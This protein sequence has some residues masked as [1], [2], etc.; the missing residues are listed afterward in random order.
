M[1]Y[2]LIQGYSRYPLYFKT[3]LHKLGVDMNVFRIGAYKSAVE[4]YTRADMSPDD[5]A[6]SVAYLDTLWTT[7]Q[8]DVTTARHLAPD[9]I[10]NYVEAFPKDIAAAGGSAARAALKAGLVTGLATRDEVRKRLIALVGA[11]DTGG[12]HSISS[13][14]YAQVV[15]DEN[16]LSS[17]DRN[18]VA[19]IIAS[20]EILDG[21]QP[22]GAIGGDST[23]RLLREARLDDRIKAVVLRIDSP[24]GSVSASDEIY[25]A[26]RALEAAGKPVVVSMGSLAASGGYYISAP[27]DQIWASP[28]TI[29]G[30][31]GI[32]AVV[33]TISG[34]LK[35]IGI[36]VD[37]VGTTPLSGELS[38]I[39][40]LNP[41]ARTFLKDTVRFGYHQFVAHVAA[42]RHMTAAQVNAIGQGHVWSGAA[43]LRLG[44]VDHLGDL[45]DAVRAAAHLAKLVHY[46]ME[47]LRMRLTWEQQFAVD[48]DSVAVRTLYSADP[49][50]RASA[51]LAQPFSP[52]T[53]QIERLSHFTL[54]G[55]LYAYCFCSVQ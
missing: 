20:G 33:P 28:A 21:D 8:H 43:A 5:R 48:I 51:R 11:N 55:Q 4:Q 18:R 31:I 54:P 1:G 26:I 41:P 10:E 30:S 12:F 3:V 37:G 32:F 15:H 24:G 34:T 35:K 13:G 16:A 36:G 39:R 27:A 45:H 42:G 7:Y 9:A 17:G 2:V 6:Q 19:V 53:Q 29:T 25:H 49:E 40:P 14:A 44:L 23:S 22:P 46:H 50:L 38:V 52:L 47:F